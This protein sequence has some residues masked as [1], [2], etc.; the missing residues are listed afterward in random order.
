M[1]FS[2]VKLSPR[3]SPSTH[4]GARLLPL[5]LILTVFRCHRVGA[6]GPDSLAFI[7]IALHS[8]RPNRQINTS[9]NT[10]GSGILSLPASV[11]GG[12]VTF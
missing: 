8:H 5:M 3:G 2:L 4:A 10:T 12:S 11:M 9:S 6:F 1:A 7:R